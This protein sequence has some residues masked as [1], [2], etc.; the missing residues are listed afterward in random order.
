M[1]NNVRE[2]R[3]AAQMTQAALAEA[4]NTSQQQ[5]QRIESGAQTVR[6]DVAHAIARALKTPLLKVFP[7]DEPPL[8]ESLSKSP[9]FLATVT[10]MLKERADRRFDD[11]GVVYRI[12]V[13]LRG[14]HSLEFPVSEFD[15]KRL[16]KLLLDESPDQG[17]L[18]F[19]SDTHLIAINKHHITRAQTVFDRVDSTIDVE[20]LMTSAGTTSQLDDDNLVALMATEPLPVKIGVDA[21]IGDLQ[22]DPPGQLAHLFYQLECGF[23]ESDF[24]TFQD[25]DGQAAYFSVGDV[26][27]IMAH[28]QWVAGNFDV[29]NEEDEGK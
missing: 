19:D 3:K 24:F 14:G 7:A 26:A 18:A 6:L 20:S 11:S 4:A 10:R 28:H 27:A 8:E 22:S 21:D 15:T 2:L 12:L 25:T 17:Y 23:V 29:W 13:S 1:D 5:I 16:Q 9:E